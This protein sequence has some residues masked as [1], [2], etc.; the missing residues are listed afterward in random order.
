VTQKTILFGILN[1]GLGHASR[2]IPIIRNLIGNPAVNVIL[3]ADGDAYNL[4]SLEFPT[5]QILRVEDVH[6]RYSRGKWL[7]FGLLITGIKL[8]KINRNEHKRVSELVKRYDVDLIISDNR[9]GFWDQSVENIMI[10]HQLTLL[11][12]KR[13]A[14]MEFFFRRIVRNRLAPF[15]EVWVPD[16]EAEP[17][18]AGKLSHQS[19]AHPN[20]RHI[21]ML[22]RYGK[23]TPSDDE[24]L[25]LMAMV[26]GPMPFRRQLSE[27]LIQI[28]E[29]NATPLV[30]YTNNLQ[31][32]V[33]DGCV[34][35]CQNASFEELNRALNRSE[36]V[37]ASAGYTTLMDLIALDKKAVL[38]PTPGQ[39]EQEYLA[40][41]NRKV[42]TFDFLPFDELHQLFE[43]VAQ[44]RM[45]VEDEYRPLGNRQNA[46]SF[47]EF[48]DERL[49]F[50]KND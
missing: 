27:K 46:V 5:L 13:F 45:R 40:E 18:L 36:M 29:A 9:Y 50:R 16:F 31:M 8:S 19:E 12:P 42:S 41:I 10:T 49:N 25:P 33:P 39:T 37:V 4:L 48:I 26:S 43:R 47:A 24:R 44:L 21:G 17:G 32:E 34:K 30:L 20:V 22:S 38:I 14:M 3:A 35:V 15:D 11:P 2:S 6:V 23:E 28:A 1:W 7:P